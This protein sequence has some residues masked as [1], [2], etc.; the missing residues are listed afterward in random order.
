[1]LKTGT[2]PVLPSG[3][4]G[5]REFLLPFVHNDRVGIGFEGCGGA[6]GVGFWKP[7]SVN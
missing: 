4:H 6:I 7:I 2:V 3:L 5:P 1:M